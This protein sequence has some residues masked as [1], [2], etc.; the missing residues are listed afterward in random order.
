[1]SFKV[2]QCPGCMGLY[3]HKGACLRTLVWIAWLMASVLENS[4]SVILRLASQSIIAWQ[5]QDMC[6]FV[7]MNGLKA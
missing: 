7:L 4:F 1:M 6:G 3:P 2:L 5:T